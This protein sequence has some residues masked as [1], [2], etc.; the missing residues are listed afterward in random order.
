NQSLAIATLC[1]VVVVIG[2][3]LAIP[4]YMHT[5]GA[6]AATQAAGVDYLTWYLPGLALQFAIVAMGSALRG[7]GIAQPTMLVQMATVVLNA[8]LA[9]VLIAGW[10]S[11]HPLGVAGAGLATTISIAIG[12]L[13]L[14]LY[15]ARLEKFVGFDATLWSPR[16]DTW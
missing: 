16:L 1:A 11:G 9:P 13:L 6:D 10:G 2:G 15:F 3:W 5:L 4:P 8:I 7:T 12:V 14:A